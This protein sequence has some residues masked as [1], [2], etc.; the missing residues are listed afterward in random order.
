MPET[1]GSLFCAWKVNHVSAFQ[2]K[3]I[4]KLQTITDSLDL[5]SEDIPGFPKCLLVSRHCRG[6][7]ACYFF[8]FVQKIRVWICVEC[9]RN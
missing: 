6:G 2:P 3:L 7:M 5:H 1:G 8:F 4:H 9:T